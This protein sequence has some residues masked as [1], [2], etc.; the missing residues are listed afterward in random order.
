MNYL[1]VAKREWE[2]WAKAKEASF[3]KEMEEALFWWEDKNA[4]SGDWLFDWLVFA[5]LFS[6]F[7]GL[8]NPF[9]NTPNIFLSLFLFFLL[10]IKQLV[11]SNQMCVL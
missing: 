5:G 7:G 1:C 11:K 3:P 8:T 4:S 6:S 2:E 10:F 9:L